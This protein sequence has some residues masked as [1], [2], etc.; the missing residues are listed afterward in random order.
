MSDNENPGWPVSISELRARRSGNAADWNPLDCLR[1]F[2]RAIEEGKLN[3]DGLIVC[4]Y[5]EGAEGG[6]DIKYSSAMPNIIMAAGTLQRVQSLL[7]NN[8]L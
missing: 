6:V 4:S 7:D 3:P 8:A 1:D 2:V 5:S